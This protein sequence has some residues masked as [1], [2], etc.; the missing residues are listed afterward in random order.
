MAKKISNIQ[1]EDARILFRNFSGKTS[2]QNPR[3]DRGFSVVLDP[4]IV[5]Q[6]QDDGWNVKFLNPR[7]E[8]DEPTPILNVA[9]RYGV[10]DPTVFMIQGKKKTLL[11]DETI[12]ILDSMDIISCDMV[13]TPYVWSIP[14]KSGVKAY[15]KELYVVCEEDVFAGKYD[16]D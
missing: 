7:E 10:V 2:Q 15:V 1:I 14:G 3:G 11:N 4:A 9:V 12:G 8:G 5:P 6:L 16:F 13:I